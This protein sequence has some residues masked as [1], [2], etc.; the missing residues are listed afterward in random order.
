MLKIT[1]VDP[2]A[3]NA[4]FLGKDI[5]VDRIGVSEVVKAKV[6]AKTTKSKS[7]SKN[8]NL[9]KSFLIKS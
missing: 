9:V 6:G 7:K 2:L 1:T 4:V 5:I 8:K 3:T